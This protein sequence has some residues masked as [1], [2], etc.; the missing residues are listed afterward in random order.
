MTDLLWVILIVSVL[1]APAALLSKVSGL[2]W[3]PFWPPDDPVSSRGRLL[4]VLTSVL[5]G[6]SAM[7]FAGAALEALGLS[8]TRAGADLG[9]VTLAVVIPF[10][11]TLLMQTLTAVFVRRIGGDRFEI[12][13]AMTTMF[14]VYHIVALGTATGFVVGGLLGLIFSSIYSIHL[15]RSHWFAIGWT[16]LAHGLHNAAAWVTMQF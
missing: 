13:A 8:R 14:T 15:Q 10:I 6:I 16:T 2:G 9:F 1:T 7:F 5:F 11:E 4:Q 3:I 12:L